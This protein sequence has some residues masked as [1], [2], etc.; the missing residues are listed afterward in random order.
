MIDK[1]LKLEL[2]PLE[3][4]AL[5]SIAAQITEGQ[6]PIAFARDCASIANPTH[7]M[8]ARAFLTLADKMAKLKLEMM[9]IPEVP[10]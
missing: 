6:D 3:A 5:R 4:T 7:S 10:N 1:Y 8:A 9:E 2:T